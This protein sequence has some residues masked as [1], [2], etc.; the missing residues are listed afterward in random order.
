MPLSKSRDYL[1]IGEV[2]ELLKKDFPDVSVSKLRF[3]ESENL[4]APPR[5]P[6]GYRKFFA[7]DVDRL[8]YIL[9]LQRDHFLPLKVIRER[10]EAIDAGSS[11]YDVSLVEA[12]EPPT[13]APERLRGTAEHYDVDLTGTQLS[14]RELTEATG[15]TEEQLT[16]LEEFGLLARAEGGSYDE[17]DLM[18]GRAARGLLEHGLEPR[19]LRM[20]RQFADREAAFYEQIVS[21]IAH[22]RDPDARSLA[23]RSLQELLELSRQMREAALRSSLRGLR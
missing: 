23:Y 1:S 17:N 13:A 4:V 7:G 19:H 21:P 3:L 8:R 11:G 16:G 10:L 15:L 20:Y 6:S 5:T 2:L 22:R 14:R 9:S 12:G 18:V